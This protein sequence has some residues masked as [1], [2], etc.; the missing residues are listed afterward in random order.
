VDRRLRFAAE[1]LFNCQRARSER[2]GS[3]PYPC[4]LRESDHLRAAREGESLVG[5]A[6]RGKVVLFTKFARCAKVITFAQRV[7]LS[8]VGKADCE[9]R[10]EL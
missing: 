8:R 2:E 3:L 1:R 10:L 5:R 9:S 7:G 4:A 6:D